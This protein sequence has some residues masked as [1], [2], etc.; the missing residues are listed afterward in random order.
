VAGVATTFGAMSAQNE[1]PPRTTLRFLLNALENLLDA[2][3][4]ADAVPS[5]DARAR[6]GMLKLDVDRALGAGREI[7]TR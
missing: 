3:D 4:G 6:F 2:V 1:P 5:P 7:A